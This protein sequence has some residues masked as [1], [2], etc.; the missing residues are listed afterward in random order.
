MSDN[1][2][3]QKSTTTEE[4]RVWYSYGVNSGRATGSSVESII[5]RVQQE[6]QGLINVDKVE[7]R[8]VITFAWRTVS[9]ETEANHG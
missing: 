3:V 1:N 9:M 5:Q 7:R 6:T 2:Q 8:T 4:V